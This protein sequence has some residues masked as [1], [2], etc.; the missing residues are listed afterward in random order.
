MYIVIHIQT[1]SLYH[2]FSVWLDTSDTSSWNRNP[3]NFTLDLPYNCSAISV[4]YDSSGIS[5]YM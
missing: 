5:T 3:P 2:N 1:V 4:T